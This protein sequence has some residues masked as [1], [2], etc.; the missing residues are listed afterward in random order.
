[1]EHSRIHLS[2]ASINGKEQDFINQAFE[3]GWLS[4]VGPQI[5][6]FERNLKTYLQTDK[7]L[8]ALSSGTAAIHLGLLQ[9]G[10]C[11]SD[12]VI[13]QSFTFVASANPI[14]YLGAKPVFVDSEL[15]TW[16]MSPVFLTEA[17]EDRIKKTGKAP[18]A[19]LIV[20][21][22]GMPAKMV[23]IIA[24]AKKYA[25]PILEDAAEALGSYIAVEGRKIM[26]GAMGDYSVF[27]FNGN[28]I[29]TTSGG[30]ALV[31]PDEQSAD[32]VRFFAGQ[33]RDAAPHYE[34]SLLGY[35][36]RLSNISAALGQAQVLSLSDYVEKRRRI[37]K[38]YRLE[39]AAYPFLTFQDEPNNFNSNYWLTT[40][41][42]R[43][44]QEREAVRNHL[45]SNNIESRPLWKPLHLQPLYAECPF[46]GD[47][48]AESLFEKGL[49]L[50]SSSNLTD[51]EIKR[52]SDLIKEIIIKK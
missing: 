23:E 43:S 24:I 32:K 16:N 38:L 25:I 46:Y 45:L 14:T 47:A 21:L 19:I 39:L 35:N 29:I 4:T 50:P 30:G 7:A 9:L 12:E 6:G 20:D 17:I 37:N 2:I 18:K 10:V 28:K 52:I 42:F 33:A 51:L 8:V 27:S 1:M 36:Y 15:D 34:H 11:S 31:C 48:V 13:C 44:Y 49:C 40:L 22:Y 5:D 26:C 41:V 3:Q